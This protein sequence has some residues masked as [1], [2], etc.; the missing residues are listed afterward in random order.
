M[1]DQVL[2]TCGMSAYRSY[3]IIHRFRKHD[4]EVLASSAT[5]R[6]EGEQALISFNAAARAQ[7]GELM[8]AD[9]EDRDQLADT[10]WG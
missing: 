1:A 9:L 2:K 3:R 8:K 6:K 5:K 4:E 10:H 7:L